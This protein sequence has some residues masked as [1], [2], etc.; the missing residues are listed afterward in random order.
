[1]TIDGQSDVKANEYEIGVDVPV[2]S[3]FAVSVG[4]GQSKKKTA[5]VLNTKNTGYGVTGLYTLSKRTNVYVG[6][7]NDTTK[8]G[9]G[10]KTAK[11][12]QYGVGIRHNF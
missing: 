8:N 10:V 5:G 11:D 3:S 7:A 1:V 4:Y 12:T 9:A 2:S 6:L